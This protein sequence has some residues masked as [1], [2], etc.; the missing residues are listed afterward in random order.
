MQRLDNLP[1]NFI[2][3]LSGGADSVALFHCLLESGYKEFTACHLNHGLRGL[4]SDEDEKFVAALCEEHHIDLESQKIDLTALAKEKRLSLETCAREARLQFFATIAKQRHIETVLLAHHTDD[5]VETCLMN[6]CRGSYSLKGI[7]SETRISIKGQPLRLLRP[8]LQFRK[9]ELVNYLNSKQLNWREDQTNQESDFT[10]NAFRN[11]V[12]PLLNET[13][14]R[15]V[16]PLI[17]SAERQA[18][19]QKAIIAELI[20]Q[21]ELEDPQGRLYLPKLAPL[22]ATLQREIVYRYLIQHPISE[23][24]QQKIAECCSLISDQSIAKVNLPQGLYFRRKEKRLFVSD[25]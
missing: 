10:R 11:K 17:H 25:H 16:V 3:A 9:E 22:S 21:L 7:N 6:L 23:L 12:I 1:Q 5:N 24:N 15:D 2:L 14:K 4:E 19:E 18:N 8:F 20:N 13:M